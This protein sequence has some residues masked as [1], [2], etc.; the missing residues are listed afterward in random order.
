MKKGERRRA[1]LLERLADH[2]LAHGLHGT[3][4]R[5]LAAAV[6]TSDRMLLHYFADKEALLTASLTVVSQRLID[7]LEAARAAPL[8]FDALLGLLSGMVKD[9]RVQPYMRLWLELLPLAAGGQE[10]FR[11]TARHISATLRGWIAGALQVDQE[12]EREPLAALTLTIVEGFVMFDALGEEAIP[13]AARI[14]LRLR[15]SALPEAGAP[16]NGRDRAGEE[17]EGAPREEG[18]RSIA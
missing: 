2:M 17:A 3:S 12:E 7:M 14:G 5:P 4:L 8:P 9:P 16:E 18:G 6:G 13:A 11:T 1:E 10:P 15:L